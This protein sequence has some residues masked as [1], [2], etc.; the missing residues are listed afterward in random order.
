MNALATQGGDASVNLTASG[1][2]ITDGVN[3]VGMYA[4][5]YGDGGAF[6]TAAGSVET[7]QDGADAA[8]AYVDS[9][10]PGAVSV[11][12]SSSASL[13]TRGDNAKGAWAL[14]GGMGTV[15]LASAGEVQTYGD[16][17]A[18]LRAQI[19]NAAN[20][21]PI[22]LTT[23][24]GASVSTSGN[25]ATGIHATHAGVGQVTIELGGGA[26]VTTSGNGSAGA[27]G[28]S[29]GT[30]DIAI[31][32]AVSTSGNDSS[33]VS[34]SS[35]GDTATI[36]QTAGSA[37]TA[38]GAN[39]AG[40]RAAGD[41]G[42]KIASNGTVSAAGEYG[43]GL[44]ATTQTGAAEIAIGAGTTVTGGWQ[45]TTSG[46]G[47]P[48]GVAAAGVQ[49]GSGV[50]S[51]LTNYGTIQAGSDRAIGQVG[52]AG[53]L[54]IENYGTVTGFVELAGGGGNIFNN[55][56][57]NSFD[58]RHF[59]DTDLD[60]I[61]D[62]KRVAISDFG[63]PGA[64]F[65]NF[66]PGAVRF[67]DVL[68][69]KTTDTSGFYLP[70]TGTNSRALDVAFYDMARE[71][72]VQGQF[73]NLATFNN[74]GLVDLRG[75]A[76]GNTLVMTANGA[77]G[78][79][80]GNGVFV[81]NGGALYLNAILNAGIPVAGQTGS[82]ADMLIV[83]GTQLGTGATTI[84]VT[85]KGGLGAATLGN[86]IELVEVRNKAASA[87]R[88]FALNGDYVNNGQQAL[89]A[90]AYGYTL[91][92]NG[93]GADADDGNWYLRSTAYQPGVPLY[94]AYPNTLLRLNT[95]PTLRQRVGDKNR[96]QAFAPSEPETIFCKD[97][98]QNFRCIINNEQAAYYLD[99][100]PSR[101]STGIWG[102][103]EAG[104]DRIDP[105]LSTSGMTFATNALQVQAGV[106]T[107]LVDSDQGRLIAALTVQYGT[108]RS[109]ITSAN[110]EGSIDTTA[111]GLGGSL[112]WLGETGFYADAQAQL[113]RSD[114]TLYS[115]TLGHSMV[116]HN[117]GM[118]YAVGVEVGQDVRLG[119]SWMLT[120]QIQLTYSTVDFDPFVDPYG[121]PVSL[122]KG[123]SLRGRLGL[124]SRYQSTWKDQSG[125]ASSL[126]ATATLNLYNEFLD[127]TQV[128][129]AGARFSS[130]GDRLW[131]GIGLG[132]TYHWADGKYALHGEISGTTS[133]MNFGKSASLSGTLGLTVKW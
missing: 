70:T 97:A 9:N 92:H 78:G 113:N 51:L 36:V 111:Y 131:G 124:G 15:T 112:T 93:V 79:P 40:I 130:D 12:L 105:R 82:N 108:A 52:A 98:S 57:F 53:S 1:S 127:G 19:S 65:N 90:G 6:V 88:A 128:D 43:V 2:I 117:N 109:D 14:S 62:T 102:R 28:E 103:M 121:A 99:A 54:R 33:G 42:A 133:L 11:D 20:S 100:N 34:A 3:A 66:A 27:L 35:S 106:D 45:A 72:V 17:S 95:L 61:R 37:I 55:R 44:M 48:L 31:A 80:A 64:V 25:S 85:N 74:A 30:V 60:G 76:V 13:L 120:P 24:A 116:S 7:K 125:E 23:S 107:L 67:L 77:A 69:A 26:Y 38:D 119:D 59:T 32:G 5:N 104:H 122:A 96:G 89:V 73:T 91:N 71:G 115:R 50:T 8:L 86:G 18:G 75:P 56:S 123:D 87:A 49:I 118:G 22:L 94:E 16:G 29:A 83:D 114:S 4:L 47:A 46:V 81:S 84:S 58:I 39:S 41:T 10:G 68:G 110:G 63:G 129:V 21:Q 101:S 126:D 132:G